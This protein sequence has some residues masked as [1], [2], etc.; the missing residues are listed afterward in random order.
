MNGSLQYVVIVIIHCILVIV[1]L[2][3]DD[4]I[5][6][7]VLRNRDRRVFLEQ[8]MPDLNSKE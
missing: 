5:S 4:G 7:R 8:V 2:Y 6:Q 3:Y 1:L